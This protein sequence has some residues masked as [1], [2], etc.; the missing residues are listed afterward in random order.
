M[1]K[2]VF[3]TGGELFNKGAQSMTFIIIDQMKR[4]Y[5]DA[6]IVVLSTRDF[7]R[8]EE[9]KKQYNFTIMPFTI[10]WIY[11]LAG[12]SLGMLWKTKNLLKKSQP[13]KYE[14]YKTKL[15]SMLN[16]AIA[17]IDTSG[18]ALSSQFRNERSISFLLTILLAKKRNIKMVVM[19]QSFGPFSYN[20]KSSFIIKSLMKQA[21]PYPEKIYAREQEGYEM[22]KGF[23]DL[24]NVERTFDMV[25]L[26]DGVNYDNIYNTAPEITNYSTISGVGIVPN[27]ENFKHGNKENLLGAYE[28]I[29]NKIL[30]YGKKVYIV[31]HSHNDSETCK[32]VKRLFENNPNVILLDEDV[33][34]REFDLLVKQFDFVIGSRFHA[35]VHSYKN[36]VPCIAI[37]WATK[38]HEL[39][40]TFN[41][42][43]YIFDVRETINSDNMEKAVEQL[44]NNHH[45][46]SIII[47][48][49][50]NQIQSEKD[51]FSVF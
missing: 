11:D 22:L 33:S 14:E 10:G 12:G 15:D 30:N 6:E 13:T 31:K 37:G 43:A 50:L 45:K 21:L 16:N 25:L 27:E 36:N 35:I 19:P 40:E 3:I 4:K 2:Y 41:Q 51:L 18:Y 24:P 38:Y 49:K 7:E 20:G 29:I 39:L 8:S 48:E 17:L 47:E 28:V 9:D 32:I 44:L 42:S 5:P 34:A 26:N 1:K 46:E 23:A